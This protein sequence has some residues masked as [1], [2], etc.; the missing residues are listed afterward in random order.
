MCSLILL[1]CING[2]SG[3]SF[4]LQK[5]EDPPTSGFATWRGNWSGCAHYELGDVTSVAGMEYLAVAVNTNSTPPSDP[6]VLLSGQNRSTLEQIFNYIQKE[7]RSE[8][9]KLTDAI[10]QEYIR[11]YVLISILGTSTYSIVSGVIVQ[12]LQTMLV[13]SV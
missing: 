3:N 10:D 1:A 2:R 7:Q 11:L 12:R 13:S 4:L 9:V 8:I 6:W 5:P